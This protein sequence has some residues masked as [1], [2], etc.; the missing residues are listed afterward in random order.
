MWPITSR[1]LVEACALETVDEGALLWDLHG[2]C[3]GDRAPRR[4]ELFVALRENGNDSHAFVQAQLEAGAALA[5]VCADWPGLSQL[6]GELRARCVVAKDSRVAFRKLAALL[7]ARFSFPVLAVGGSNGKTTVK[8]MLAAMMCGGGRRISATRETM[9]GW[10][11]LPYTLTR[12]AHAAVMPPHALVVEIGIDAV[13]AM[14]EHAELVAPDV[15]V[16]TALGPEHLAGLQDADTA[17]REELEL[18]SATPRARHV[19]QTADSRIRAALRTAKE[20]DV[21]VCRAHARLEIER[22]LPVPLDRVTHEIMSESPTSCHVWLAHFPKDAESSSWSGALHVPMPGRHNADNVAAAFAAGLAAGLRPDEL[23]RGFRAFTPPTMRCQVRE[24]Y[25]D[26]SLVDDAYNASPESV[27]AALALLSLSAWK[28]RRKVL[29]LGDMLDLGAES[30]RYH[31]ELV[32]PLLDLSARGATVRLVGAAMEP[33][34]RALREH[35][36]SVAHFPAGASTAEI[37]FDVEL[38]DAVVLVK[39]SRGMHLEHVVAEIVATCAAASPFQVSGRESDLPQFY[40]RFATAAV[41]GTNG[42]TTTT[43]LIAHI[44]GTSGETPCRVT[45]LGSW[46]GEERT[47]TEPTGDAFVQTLAR[48]AVRGVRTL[49]VETTSLALGQGFTKTWPAKVAVFT[50][51]TRDHLDYH[52]SPEDYLAAKA[53]L[54]MD[55]PH[56]GV[57]V[58]NLADPA[59]A[60]LAELVPEGVRVLGYAA[61][62]VDPEC[63]ELPL[64]LQADEVKVDHD[65]TH[66]RLAPSEVG[67]A[68][69]N[70]I[71]LGLLGVVHAENALAAALAGV[72]LGYSPQVIGVAL[73]SFRGVPG[74]FQIVHTRPIVVVD[75]AHTPDAL[76]RTLVQ[77]RALV[78]QRGGRVLLVF[79]CG[80]DRDPGKRAPMGE[81]ASKHADVVCLTND[82]P[83]SEDPEKIADAV[84]SG[85]KEGVARLLRIL[86]RR[87]AIVRAIE[88]A[89]PDDIV[90][91]CGKGHEK[92][93]VIGDT[94]YPF[95]D[96]E[97]V[98]S[99]LARQR[100]AQA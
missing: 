26:C 69:G 92:D 100:G 72:A 51:L 49:A 62:P 63:K 68:L 44:V 73:R 56:N 34:F 8:D 15:C 81:I 89:G 42:K 64:S 80:G 2:V 29:V 65:G 31:E 12:R 91:V 47:G 16:L 78:Q 3:V 23:L 36:A 75:F 84:E 94:T 55:L 99:I 13:G 85:M 7:R 71:D 9:N 77:S 54:F 1:E 79:G 82:N 90:V 28:E 39:G 95:D 76:T 45:T 11:G 88:L 35:G 24:L 37:L 74:R 38:Q 5:L 17:A 25:G 43:S 40:G 59:S 14:K 98:E 21:I 27:R 70:A 48:A 18:F 10:T 6:P 86:D 19:F 60:L 52:G 46:V 41:T 22:V 66:L 32:A 96:V 93:Q 33:V 58:L 53:Q 50:N 67:D 97:V 4:D 83:R 87:D 57:A 61:R 30:A 20:G